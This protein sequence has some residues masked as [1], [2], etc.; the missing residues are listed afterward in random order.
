MGYLPP[1]TFSAGGTVT[2]AMWNSYVR[3]NIKALASKCLL[4]LGSSI[5]ISGS[6]TAQVNLANELY[7][8]ADGMGD[9]TT[10]HRITIKQAGTYRVF[11]EVGGCLP[12]GA[13]VTWFVKQNG[14]TT[15]E[16]KTVTNVAECFFDFSFAFAVNDFVELWVTN[17]ATA[18][19]SIAQLSR[20]PATVMAVLGVEWTA[21]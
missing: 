21:P 11:V 5:T 8:S 3:D 20:R 10:N 1:A 6:L 15:L 19:T 7:D 9:P 17:G 16:S 14:A 2:A 12:S 4:Y 18:V 13:S